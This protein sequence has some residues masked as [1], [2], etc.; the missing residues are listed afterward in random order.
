MS[1]KLLVV[2]FGFAACSW[3][4][5]WAC[6]YYRLET[7]S[8]FAVGRWT[9][10]RND[11]VIALLVYSLL[12]VANLVS[13]VAHEWR[14]LSA[15]LSGSGHLALGLLHAYRLRRPFKFEV[16]GHQWSRAASAREAVIAIALGLLC[17]AIAVLVGRG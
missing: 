1:Q 4:P 6:H 16:F 17:F 8:G 10:S 13:C 2:F 14:S 7:R 15:V 9:F 5:H 3:M 12:I 11:S